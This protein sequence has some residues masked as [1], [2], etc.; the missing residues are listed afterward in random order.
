MTT[1]AAYPDYETCGTC[2]LMIFPI[3]GLLP[4]GHAHATT[5]P[6]DAVG[7]VYSWTVSWL[8]GQPVTVVMADFFDGALRV[9]APLPSNEQVSIDDRVDV[10]MSDGW[11]YVMTRR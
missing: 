1:A 9:T 3:L 11:P 10:R 7:T 2:G 8:T 4:C 5:A 6:L